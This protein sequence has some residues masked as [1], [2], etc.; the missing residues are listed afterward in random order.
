LTALL[1]IA[2]LSKD[3]QGLRPLRIA[4]LS[5]TP[6][7]VLVLGGLDAVAAQALVHLI[8]GAALPDAGDV[9]LFGQNTRDI[10]DGEAWL[11]SLDGLGMVTARGILIEAFSVL[12]NIAMSYTLDVDPIDPR[13]VPQAG[14]VARGVGIDPSMFDAPAGKVPL[15]VQMRVHLARSLALGPKMLVAEHPSAML[16]RDTVAAFGA[17]LAR[18]AQS[19]GLGLLAITADEVFAKALGGRRV[20]L[21]AATGELRAPGLLKKLFG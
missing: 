8:T 1:E 16:P 2:G 18:A 14:E 11:L 13:V 12:Q 3:Y 15:D 17:D 9:T 19:R 6:G 10:K 21:V 7:E 20:E 4:Q 5:V